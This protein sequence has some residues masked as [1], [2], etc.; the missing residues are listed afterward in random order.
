MLTYR[1]CSI[2]LTLLLL[3]VPSLR[4]QSETF[5]AV[6][7]RSDLHYLSAQL[8]RHHPNLELYTPPA[9]WDRAV[10]TLADSAP[11]AADIHAAYRWI[12]QLSA[13]IRDGHTHFYPPAGTANGKLLPLDLHLGDGGLRMI[14]D[15]TPDPTHPPGYQIY[16]LHGTAVPE[17]LATLLPGL[18][19]DAGNPQYP[20]WIVQT[21][22]APVYRSFYGTP[23]RFELDIA[24]PEGTRK[25]VVLAPRTAEE[26]QRTRQSRYPGARGGGRPPGIVFALDSV[27]GIAVLRIGTFYR[28]ARREPDPG[29]RRKTIRAAFRQLARTQTERLVVDLRGN[30]GGPIKNGNFL[31]AQFMTERYRLVEAYRK[32]TRSGLRPCAGP[33]RGEKKPRRDAFAGQVV[34]LTDG[35]S[36]SCAAIVAGAVKRTRRARIIGEETGG[37]AACLAGGGRKVIL[38]ETKI[39]VV[40]PDLRFEMNS[41]EV[42]TPD[43]VLPDNAIIP[44]LADIL[45]GRDPAREKARTLL[46]R[47]P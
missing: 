19:N 35:G 29:F 40:I 47:H 15:L 8:Q 13:V 24:T 2:W 37:N 28:N 46:Q 18:P 31:L 39:R 20:N 4:A 30:Q 42:G 14:H 10:A 26:I 12:S 3:V 34:L 45:A 11:Q 38:P 44:T 16:R 32:R 17:L 9:D 27:S 33:Q 23:A 25:T 7:L 36:F 1:I 5:T 22:F 43:G 21:L 6:Q 41:A